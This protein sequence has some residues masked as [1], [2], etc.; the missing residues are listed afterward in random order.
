M[1]GPDPAQWS[2]SYLSAYSYTSTALNRL[3]PAAEWS[4]CLTVSNKIYPHTVGDF[5]S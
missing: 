2:H 4:C 3:Q 1:A 5:S